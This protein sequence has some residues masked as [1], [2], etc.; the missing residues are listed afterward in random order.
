MACHSVL[1]L[2]MVLYIMGWLTGS[3]INISIE[4]QIRAQV[5]I[6]TAKGSARRRL[7]T[8]T[9]YYM[10][11]LERSQRTVSLAS[12]QAMPGWALTTTQELA[13]YGEPRQGTPSMVDH[14]P[15]QQIRTKPYSRDRSNRTWKRRTDKVDPL[16][17]EIPITGSKS[18]LISLSIL[19]QPFHQTLSAGGVIAG[20][21]KKPAPAPAK[22]PTWSI[23]PSTSVS[24]SA[25]PTLTPYA[26]SRNTS[27]AESLDWI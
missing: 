14:N 13:R 26:T 22:P 15:T 17:Y 10:N 11:Y 21:P 23:A 8:S 3:S 25:Q 5:A 6:N 2:Y 16:V 18:M 1:V 9:I 7:Y 24:P 19:Y 27:T 12:I 4:L 20:S